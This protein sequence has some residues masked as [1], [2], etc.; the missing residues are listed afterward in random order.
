VQSIVNPPGGRKAAFATNG[1]AHDT[2]QAFEQG[3]TQHEGSWWPHLSGWLAARSDA[4]KRAPKSAGSSRHP[5]L[6]AAPGRY[7][8]ESA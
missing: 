3:A 4:M 2:P 1:G 5:S 7:V 6:G 8:V